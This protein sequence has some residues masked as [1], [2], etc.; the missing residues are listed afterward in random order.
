MQS[1]NYI[2]NSIGSFLQSAISPALLLL[3]TRL[4]G[5]ADSGIFSFALSLS[6]VFWAIGLWGGRTYQVSDV[7]K[8]FSS[9]SYLAVK[10]VTSIVMMVGA[11]LFCAA[12][13]YDV[14]K[15]SIIIALVLFK[16]LEAVA[17][18][19]YGVLQIHHRLY[20]VGYSLTIKAVGGFG[21]FLL[22]DMLVH[23]VLWGVIAIVIVNALMLV[24]YDWQQV[25][26][27]E[28]IQLHIDHL[29]PKLRHVGMIMQRCAPVFLTTFLTMF[30]LNIPRYFLDT[31]HTHEIAYFGIMAMPITLLSLFI[32]FIIQPNIVQLS[33]LYHQQKRL[34]FHAL[35]SKIILIV[36][37]I[38]AL[39]LIATWL[40]GAPL[41][42]LI[43]NARITDYRTELLIMVVGAVANALVSIYI[44]ILT[45][46]REFKGQFYIL[47][48]SNIVL[49]VVSYGVVQH[50]AMLGSVL[51]FMVA[52]I[53]Q[54]VLLAA[55]YRRQLRSMAV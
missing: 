21:A 6:V 46:L 7:R 23:S 55:V 25:Q 40:V 50:Y 29:M 38:S 12:N 9:S 24:L 10:L 48:L 36:L 49:T 5:I 14:V 44:N 32:T 11:V 13:H 51:C 45:V 3:I 53:I 54:A 41:L 31:F 33:E 47:L 28:S 20:V 22:V 34:E 8:E 1:K 30:S 52:G 42:T 2:W 19:L 35:V 4:N 17:D 37:G 27:Y 16:A 26:R 15:S 39:T 43:F 18:A